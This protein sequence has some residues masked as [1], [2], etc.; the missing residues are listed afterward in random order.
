M[1]GLATASKSRSAGACPGAQ[2]TPSDEAS[3]ALAADA[4][5]CLVNRERA[6]HALGKLRTSSLLGSA[7]T[8]H[9]SDMV[10]MRFFS[11]TGS[12]GSSM[13]QRIAQT[14]YLRNA[15]YA[16]IGETLAWG[17]GSYSTPSQIVASFLASPEHRQ[18]MLDRRFRDVGVGLVL[19]A[20]ASNV[21][22]GATA[23]LDFGRR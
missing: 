18:T 1:P 23:T 3:R 15:N 4:I 13:R 8:D 21:T 2:S 19:G 22:S 10:A 11:H 17:S 7:A 14:G 6:S 16:A 5:V 9:S 20:P 12:S